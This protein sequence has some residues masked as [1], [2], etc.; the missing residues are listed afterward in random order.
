MTVTYIT[1]A[2]NY[3]YVL[4]V[5]S[6]STAI[7]V[8]AAVDLGVAPGDRVLLQGKTHPSFHTYIDADSVTLLSHGALPNPVPATFDK[9]IR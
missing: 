5:Q 6:G 7:F 3:G 9:L 8:R 2:S 1:Y 4:I